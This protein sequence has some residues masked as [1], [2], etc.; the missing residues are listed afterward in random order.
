MPMTAV[1]APAGGDGRLA[2]KVALVTG[3]GRGIG[4][5]IAESLAAEGAR[6]SVADLHGC[7]DTARVIRDAGGRAAPVD[8]DLRDRGARDALVGRVVEDW[9]AL[10]VLVNNAAGHGSRIPLADVDYD[11]WDAVLEANL[12]ATAFLSTQAAAAMHLG[13][14]IVNLASIQQRLPLPTYGAYIASKGGISALSNALA[15]E[16]APDVRVNLVA[17]GVIDTESF[18]TTPGAGKMSD[19]DARPATLLGRAGTPHEVARAVVFLASDESSFITGETIT[20]DGGRTLS[21]KPDPLA[22]S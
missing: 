22:G 7:G 5:V 4:K 9:G 1:D 12:A 13:G 8:V 19:G 20:V 17:P 6:V 3:A 18:R 2:G 16:L 21:R 14:A 11:E 10:D 15:V